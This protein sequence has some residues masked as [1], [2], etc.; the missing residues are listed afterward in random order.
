M[1]TIVVSGYV[2]ELHYGTGPWTPMRAIR[3]SAKNQTSESPG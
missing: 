3:F 1:P 2:L